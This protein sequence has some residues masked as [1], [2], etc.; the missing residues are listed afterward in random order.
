M[1]ITNRERIGKALDLLKEGLAPF[2]QR[3]LENQYGKYWITEVTADW[4]YEP[5]WTDDG[6]PH[7][8]IA[9][10]LRLMWEQ[11]NPVFR[12]T[13]GHAERSLVSELRDVRNRWAHQNRFSSDDTYRALDSASRLLTAISAPR[14]N[15]T[16]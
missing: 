11:W 12:Q 5:D 13:L 9:L 1:A 2:V 6:E 16:G 15:S 8:D 3:E 14:A 7:L 4:P 10:L